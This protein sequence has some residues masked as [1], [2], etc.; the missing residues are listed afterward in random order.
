MIF[1]KIIIIINILYFKIILFCNN[2]YYFIES[3]KEYRNIENFLKI[4]S[5]IGKNKKSKKTIN[6]P[7]LSIIS[8][9]FNSERYILRFLRY[10]QCQSFNNIEIILIDD[11]SKDNSKKK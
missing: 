3:Q 8:S 10:I 6:V 1:F 5:N 9:V 11:S 7:K 4:S 2:L